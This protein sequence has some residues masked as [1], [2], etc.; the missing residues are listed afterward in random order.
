MKEI[1]S[2]STALF[3]KIRSRFSEVTL[4]D[5]NAKAE[6]DP[7]KARFFN[8]KYTS[9]DGAEFGTI[10]IS[11]IDENSLKVYYSYNISADM[12]REQRKEWYS[13]LRNLRKFARRNF[14]TFDT[15][16]INKSNLELKDIVQQSK[17]D[18]SYTSNEVPVTESRLYGSPGRPY[19]SFGDKGR[20]KLMIR[21]S[22]KVNEEVPGARTRKIESIFLETEIG[23]RFKL[24]H[25]NLHAAWALA[26]HLNQGGTTYDEFA[27]HINSMVN[28]MSAMKHFVRS[29]KH[30]QF[31]DKETVNMTEA[32]IDHYIRLRE[33]L[34]NLRSSKFARQYKESWT[35]TQTIVEDD[36]D[37]QELRE[38]FVKKYMMIDSMMHYQ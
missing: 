9:E 2:I 33:T 26:E 30:R 36:F 10:T 4:G 21:H 19:N 34:R 27:E 23:E 14:L 13:F 15:R 24:T 16:D 38:R 22:D 3:D 32:A 6:N 17:A 5:E 35:P 37:L 28:E 29:T 31:E 7:E 1:E 20:T 25:N 18:G 12:D 11:T 8:F